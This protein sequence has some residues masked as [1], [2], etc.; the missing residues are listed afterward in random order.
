MTARGHISMAMMI[1]FAPFAVAQ[2]ELFANILPDMFL[3]LRIDNVTALYFV[4]IILG[5]LV[6]DVDEVQSSI[7]KR[8][9]ILSDL[10]SFAL[11]HRTITHWFVTRVLL[12]LFSIAFLDGNA[13]MFVAS[14]VV[15]MLIHDVGD[16]MT[17][18]VRGYFW[19]LID[20]DKS[21]RIARIKVG[22]IQ[23]WMIVLGINAILILELYAV[24]SKEF[25]L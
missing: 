13:A 22:G 18:G 7:G 1:A 23:E 2:N 12:M 25:S 19:P 14:L 3:T 11:G 20:I 10:F 24:I 15:G 5:A 6:P 21:V 4:A 9:R 8:T 16:L 17:G